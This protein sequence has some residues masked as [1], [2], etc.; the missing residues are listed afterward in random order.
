MIL[1]ELTINI[2]DRP[3]Y[4][5][6]PK[7]LHVLEKSNRA[8]LIAP[9]GA[10]KTTIVPLALLDAE[11]CKSQKIIVL[12]PRRLAARSAARYMASLLGENVGETVGYRVR[13]DTKVSTSTRIEIVTEGVFTRQILGDPELNGVGAVLFDEFHERNLEGDFGLALALDA[14]CGLREDLRLLPMSATLDGASVAGFLDE[15]PIIESEGRSYPV[16]IHYVPRRG[17]ERIEDAMATAIRKALIDHQGSILA[18]LPGQR[19]IHRTANVLE[20][21]LPA[22]IFVAPLYG[23]LDYTA[24][25][26]AI[27]PAPEGKRK[28]VLAT[29]IAETSLTLEDVRI[30]IDSGLS[31]VPKYDAATGLS[32][33]E[34]VRSSQS[35]ITQ[36]AGRAGRTS[37]GIAIRLWHENQTNAF[38]KSGRPEILEADLISMALSLASWGVADPEKLSWLTSPP[39]IAWQE[40]I[41]RLNSLGA[42]NDDGSITPKGRKLSQFSL[43]PQLANMVLEAANHGSAQKAAELAVLLTERNLGGN[44][45]DVSGRLSGIRRG[46]KQVANQVRSMLRMVDKAM[47][48]QKSEE[49]STGVLLSLAFPDRIAQA[50][51]KTGHFRLANGRGAVMDDS[52]SLAKEKYLA[53]ADLQG[54]AS[55]ARI[56][57]AA[58]LSRQ[59]IGKFHG[60]RIIAQR[61][62]FFDAG[63]RRVRARLHERL[64]KLSLKQSADTLLPEDEVTPILLEGIKAQGINS[65]NWAGGAE[66]LRQKLDFLHHLKP[67]DWPDVSD[68]ILRDTLK[69]WLEPFLNSI[70]AIS[71]ITPDILVNGLQYYAGHENVAR[72]SSLLPSHFTAPTGS[73]IPIAYENGQASLN[74]RVQEL[75]GL[76]THPTIIDN[77]PILI[78]LLSPAQ[79]P[80]QKTLDLPRFWKGSWA[81]VRSDMRG[82]YPKHFWPENPAEA[83]ATS[84]AK[85]R[86]P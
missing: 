48:Q 2:T 37:P 14:Q 70:S 24:Q 61:E 57:S 47:Q 26:A 7:L 16:D 43:G 80:I 51:G 23:G 3:V 74:V 41:S 10:G 58:V 1:R 45:V 38:E 9:P 29:S 6:L 22:N 73:K 5:C 33:L 55:G 4:Q 66:K 72:L 71:E 13:M 19:E 52:I 27:K 34:T 20:G 64:G 77:V 59:E 75:F 83:E 46:G 78:N 81:D 62:V 76:M 35:S 32:R 25:D 30:V 42:I 82:R 84:R 67:E 49:L 8:V 39:K 86:K 65:L 28:I 79:R 85:P 53:V 12:E 31:R 18:F 56:M 69:Q 21:R 50:R 63:E 44:S 36:R 54:A 68:D 15:A 40:A 60:E 11:W 17:D